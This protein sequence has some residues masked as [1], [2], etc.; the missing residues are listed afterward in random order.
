MEEME[1]MVKVEEMGTMVKMA[2]MVALDIQE[3][4]EEMEVTQLTVKTE[5][6]EQSKKKTLLNNQVVKME[7]SNSLKHLILVDFQL[8]FKPR[9]LNF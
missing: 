5:P 9:A 3:A 2:L 1:F 4:V 8:L 6:M 7:E